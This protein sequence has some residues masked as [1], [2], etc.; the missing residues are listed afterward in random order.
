MSS[1]DYHSPEGHKHSPEGHKHSPE[2][3]QSAEQPS[4]SDDSKLSQ[5][6]QLLMSDELS[7]LE[8]LDARIADVEA[9]HALLDA[10][11]A[12]IVELEN[13]LV[14]REE[15]DRKLSAIKL[16]AEALSQ[17]LPVAVRK[18]STRDKQL[19]NSLSPT[20]ANAFQESVQREPEALADAVSP[21]MGPA[22]R[23]SISQAIAGMVQ[24]LNQTL[25]HGFS[26]RGLKWRWE[27]MTTGKPFAEVVL[28]HSLIYLVEHIFL[29]RREDGVVLAHVSSL[30]EDQTDPDLVSGMLTALQDFVCDSLGGQQSDQLEDMRVGER[31]IFVEHGSDAIVAAVI[32]GFP[33][34]SIRAT[35]KEAV[36][37]VHRKYAE[38]L[39][40]FDGHTDVFAPVEYDLRDCLQSAYQEQAKAKPTS[41]WRQRLQWG[42]VA[43]LMLAALIWWGLH[44][45]RRGLERAY[46]ELL[47]TPETVELE[48]RQGVLS[49]R[50]QAHDDW[51]THATV[52]APALRFVDR[53]DTSD[54]ANQDQA[55]LDCLAAL[56]DER[57]IVV[58][59][60]SREG[61]IY[62]VAG[63]QDPLAAG[64]PSR[65][66]PAVGSS[67]VKCAASLHRTTQWSPN[68]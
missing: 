68:S 43:A 37:S 6:K 64:Q 30:P 29:I 49:L 14:S 61:C 1:L 33:P 47:G 16:D 67:Q 3:Q 51:I 46:T 21:I 53:L 4:E 15:L 25:Q 20:L 44:L 58:T 23:R 34:A 56:R 66:S 22:I 45:R 35:L 32:R 40:N 26:P 62:S 10:L 65:S 18:A 41:R 9:A 27:A 59:S 48:L 60:A 42:L 7:S 36:E 31:N 2:D 19:A 50:G 24:S 13:E 8:K 55:W 28:L 39:D 5:L 63:L 11:R 17:L 52:A 12:R 38:E 57:G 54:L